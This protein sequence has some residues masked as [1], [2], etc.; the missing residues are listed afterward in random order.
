M[1]QFWRDDG[2]EVIFLHGT[3]RFIPADV[4][5]VHVDL[6]VVPD[7]YFEFASRYPVALNA[8]VR[9]I[10]KSRFSTDLL[11][12]GDLW[13]GGVI[14][15]S[16]ENC[17]GVP[18]M[19]RTSW[20]LHSTQARRARR[21]LGKITRSSRPFFRSAADYLVY[22]NLA[23]VPRALFDQPGLIVQKFLPELHDGRYSVRNMTFLGDRV[24]C[25]RLTSSS[26]IVTG[27]AN[28]TLEQVEPHRDIAVLRKTLGFDYGKF[29]YVIHDGRAVLLD[30]NKTVGASAGLLDNEALRRIRRYRAEGLYDYFR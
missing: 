6:S 22:E 19:E 10:R 16:D 25:V 11:R 29:D 2:H 9:D 15:K 17:A 28:V 12:S 27:D 24:T 14:V 1:A 5:I 7:A 30:I 23:A 21:W 13:T 26:P 18:E 20:L 4:V 3:K 8:S